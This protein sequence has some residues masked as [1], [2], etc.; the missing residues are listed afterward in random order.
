MVSKSKLV[1]GLFKLK[2][3]LKSNK[4]LYFYG[5]SNANNSS[6]YWLY[7]YYKWLSAG[8]IQRGGG[9]GGMG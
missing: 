9:G 5:S 4:M 7:S 8:K 3:I 1:F 2:Y 6:E